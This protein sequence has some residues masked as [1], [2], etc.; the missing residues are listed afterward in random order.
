LIRVLLIFL[1]SALLLT[2]AFAQ[3]NDCDYWTT[4]KRV[5]RKTVRKSKEAIIFSISETTKAELL[6]HNSGKSNTLLAEFIFLDKSGYVL[7][8]GS[9]LTLNF[10]DGTHVD[11]VASSRRSFSSVALFALLK[12]AN[13][14]ARKVMAYDDKLFYDKLTQIDIVSFL[15][16]VDSKKVKIEFSK[17]K[18]E[19]VKLIIP[20]LVRSHENFK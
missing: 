15:Y 5:N 13:K 17:A 20:C 1:T 12:P 16:T 4:E 6:F 19:L 8:L 9:I 11:V 2:S 18:S 10:S 3:S 14:T 7:E